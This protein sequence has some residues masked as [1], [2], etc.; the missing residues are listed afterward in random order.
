MFF[1]CIDAFAFSNSQTIHIPLRSSYVVLDPSKLQDLSSMWVSRQI[2]CQLVRMNGQ[3]PVLEAASSMKYVSPLVLDV[4]LK[5]DI[6]FSDGTPVAAEDVVATFN[7]LRHKQ[8]EFRNIFDWIQSIKVKGKFEVLMELKRQTPDFITALSAPHYAIFKKEFIKKAETDPELWNKP[9]GCGGYRVLE[10]NKESILLAPKAKGLPVLFTFVPKNQ[11]PIKEAM[12]YDLIVMQIKNNPKEL[13]NYHTLQVFDPYQFYFAFNTRLPV[14][15]DRKNRCS[16]F[17]KMNPLSILQQYGDN[18][19]LADNLIP[20]GILGYS[21][22]EH[23]L[24]DIK[25]EYFHTPL[26]EKDKFCVSVVST[27]IEKNY[28][29]RY[30]EMLKALYPKAKLKIIYSCS[31]MN[32]VIEKQQ[33]D[34]TFFAAKSNYLDAYEYLQELSTIKGVNPTGYYEPQLA[35]AIKNSQMSLTTEAKTK[36]YREIIHHIDNLCLMYPLFTMSYDTI[37]V[38]NG[39]LTPGL[40]QE[41]LNEYYLGNV[42]FKSDVNETL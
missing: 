7:Y 28:R 16:F 27:S 5:K 12:H 6:I 40:G 26:P 35:K 42:S 19:K 24:A 8:T 11:M 36:A 33:C 38:K 29:E 31:N 18:S 23:Y 9:I 1:I 15:K 22:N 32:Q 30:L 20:S 37:F 13:K 4:K 14:W 2:N 41:P 10:N 3:I 17:A 25:Q 39:V 21:P 34:G